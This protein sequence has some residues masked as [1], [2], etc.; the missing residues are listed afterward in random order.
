MRQS[1]WWGCRIGGICSLACPMAATDI[2]PER[3]PTLILQP[4]DFGFQD[5]RGIS[6]LRSMRAISSGFAGL[7]P[8]GLRQRSLGHSRILPRRARSPS[9]LLPLPPP[10]WPPTTLPLFFGL[11]RRRQGLGYIFHRAS[12]LFYQFMITPLRL[13]EA[14]SP[15]LA[16][17]L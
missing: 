7:L 11:L 8:G 1:Q 17:L 14:V 5:L 13:L 16:Q 4:S 12:D 9:Q 6:T 10:E 2:P 3:S 15:V